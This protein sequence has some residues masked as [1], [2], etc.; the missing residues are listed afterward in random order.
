[1]GKTQFERNVSVNLDLFW[2]YLNVATVK[3]FTFMFF[4]RV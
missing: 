3:T 1:M 4:T 2:G